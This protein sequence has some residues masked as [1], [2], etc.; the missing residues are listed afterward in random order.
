[1]KIAI[2]IPDPL[3]EQADELA[4]RL[5][6]SR[7]QVY[8]E[9][10]GEYL[11]RRDPNAVTGALNELGE[12]IEEPDQEWIQATARAALARSEW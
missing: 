4:G 6:K 3:F 7:S 11:Q 9:A 8:R 1:M 12:L 10:L 2:S 5:G